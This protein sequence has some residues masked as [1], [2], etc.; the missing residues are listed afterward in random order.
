M[1]Q[2]LRD[3]PPAPRRVR[4]RPL[5]AHR[6]LLL[7][8]GAALVVIGSLVAWLMFLQSG[9]KMSM[10]PRLAAGPT[11][12]V[13]GR[14]TRIEPPREHWDGTLRQEVRY[15]FARRIE[16]QTVQGIGGCFLT[17]APRAVDDEVEVDVLDSDPNVSC[18]PGGVMHLDVQW[19]R[20][21]FWM[22]VMAAPGALL[23]LGWA[24]S[25]FQLR[26]VLVHGDV[27][28]GVVHRVRPVPL[29]LP[30]MLRVDYTFRDHRAVTRHN[31]HWVRRHGRL[32]TRL[33][34]QMEADR[35]EEMPVLHD[36]ALPHWNRMLLPQDFLPPP[37][38]ID[39]G[40]DLPSGTPS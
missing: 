12:R 6:W 21:R 39:L 14:L 3:I 10:G 30:E 4:W 33:L 2:E 23:L 37:R 32:G 36:R 13:T 22:T 9:G 26:R 16:S 5:F 20:A 15:S 18:I 17:P 11:T 25:V 8:P 1:R 40:S 19:L 28:I 34:Q 24:A 38:A 27:S 29:V 31:R 35:Y 7:A